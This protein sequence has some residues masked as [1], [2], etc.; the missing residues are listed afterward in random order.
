MSKPR[1]R[2]SERAHDRVR[3]QP[4]RT[5]TRPW[6]RARG[7]DAETSRSQENRTA[8]SFAKRNSWSS[9]NEVDWHGRRIFV[10][11]E[12]AIATPG[13]VTK[14]GVKKSAQRA[15]ADWHPPHL[16]ATKNTQDT[17]PT[18]RRGD[19]VV[20]GRLTRR[21]SSRGFGSSCAG[22]GPAAEHQ[23]S[24]AVACECQI[25]ETATSGQR[26]KSGQKAVCVFW[27]LG[28]P[29]LGRNRLDQP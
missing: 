8:R 11:E 14:R 20:E 6:E 10:R 19:P 22:L 28:R 23:L 12:W 25:S 24:R 29:S 27:N 1:I 2:A 4:P 17:R 5:D 13:Q 7:S 3:N 18:W 15:Q 9:L 26:G 16:K 21:R